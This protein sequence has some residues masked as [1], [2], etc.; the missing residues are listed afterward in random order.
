MSTERAGQLR[1]DMTRNDYPAPAPDPVTPQPHRPEN[2]AEP[3][4]AAGWS[5]SCTRSDRRFFIAPP[6]GGAPAVRCWLLSVETEV[7]V[8][9]HARIAVRSCPWQVWLGRLHELSHQRDEVSIGAV[10]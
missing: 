9:V 4:E 2:N 3:L 1:N 5:G 10:I 8:Q 6:M 7:N